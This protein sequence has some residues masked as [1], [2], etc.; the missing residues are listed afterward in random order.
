VITLRALDCVSGSTLAE[1]QAQATSKEEVI[2]VLGSA[3]SQFRERLG[4]S[5]G[6]VQRYD[7]RVEEAT[8]PSLEALKAYS[9]G[10]FARRSARKPT[11]SRR[12]PT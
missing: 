5:L 3:A 2:S 6:M 1:E 10:G 4:E 7:T 9:Q 11:T 12:R 8:T